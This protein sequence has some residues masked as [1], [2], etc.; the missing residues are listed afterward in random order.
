M[1]AAQLSPI[2]LLAALVALARAHYLIYIK[3]HGTLTS[4]VI[5]WLSTIVAAGLWA[6]RF[7]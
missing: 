1:I 2:F 3:K 6:G 5:V 7:I 4:R